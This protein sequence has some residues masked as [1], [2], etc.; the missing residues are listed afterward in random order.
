VWDN[1]LGTAS[2]NPWGMR[3][4]QSK[5]VSIAGKTGTAQIKGEH[6]YSKQRHRMS[7]VGY[8]PEENPQY[9]CICVIH[10]AKN[11]GYY[12]AGMDCGSVVRNIAEK[13]MAYTNEYI[14]KDG[15]LIFA[16]NN[17]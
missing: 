2:V 1:D 4:A 17:R 6:G 16:Q 11:Y 14:I 13:T 9:S 10:G 5:L 8:F 12:D 3:K 7:F 15:K